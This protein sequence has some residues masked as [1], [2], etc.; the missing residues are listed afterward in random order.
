MKKY[1]SIHARVEA[2]VATIQDHLK[3]IEHW[4]AKVA[5]E[6]KRGHA[7]WGTVGT[8]AHIRECLSEALGHDVSEDPPN[9]KDPSEYDY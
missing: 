1:T 4:V 2:N 6:A 8:L 9:L 7:D 5:D 3:E